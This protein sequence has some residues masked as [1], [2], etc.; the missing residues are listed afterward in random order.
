MSKFYL[1]K[2]ILV[3]GGSGMIGRQLVQKLVSF[4]A[5]VTVVSLDDF[6]SS[7]NLKFIKCD[8]RSFDNCIKVCKNIDIVFNLAGVKGSPKMTIEQPA[9]FFV[10]TIMFSINLMEA[11]RRSNVERYLYTSSIGVYLPKKTFIEDD[12]WKTFP[13]KNDK[14]AGWAKRISE[15]QSEAYEIQYKWNK[16]SI[17]R[18]ANVYGPYDNFDINNAMVIPSLIYKSL[19]AKKYL[20]VWGDGSPIRDFVYSSDVADGMILAVKKGYTKPINLG[21]GKKTSIKKIVEIINKDIPNGPLDIKWDISKPAGDK[22][23]L[24]NIDRAVSI[25]YK[26]KINIDEGIKLT[27]QWLLSNKKELNK[28]KY[29]SFTE[30]V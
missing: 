4:G 27:I 29:N 26:P 18:P 11:A 10:P 20:E 23:R 3:A 25:G 6:K 8:L 24:M 16:I 7:K 21:S 22:I 28:K 17:V 5:L 12:V 30:K 19:N 14:F 9:S 15:L 13:S 1:K 2:R